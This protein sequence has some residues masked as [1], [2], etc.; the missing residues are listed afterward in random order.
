[1]ETIS[2]LF[3][4]AG[5]EL[6]AVIVGGILATI[7]GFLANIYEDRREQR[8]Q[9]IHLRYV[10]M[11]ALRTVQALNEGVLAQK[12][13]FF[14]PGWYRAMSSLRNEY[15][16]YERNR[17]Q[18][19]HLNDRELRTDIANFMIRL[20]LV[21]DGFM[22][23]RAIFDRLDNEQEIA[24][25]AGD[26]EALAR[27]N[28]REAQQKTFRANRISQLETIIATLPDLT[29]RLKQGLPK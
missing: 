5:S 14:D 19:V 25:L 17:E 20:S 27:L 23:D 28:A 18:M 13:F 29:E 26:K 22:D 21:A 8:R 2:T 12:Q 1:M 16:I 7:G 6:V 15:Q 4:Q 10:L 11:D 3:E 24:E 9:G